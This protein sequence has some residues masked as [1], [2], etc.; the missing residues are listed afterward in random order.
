VL[1]AGDKVALESKQM[2][3]RDAGYRSDIQYIMSELGLDYYN[4]SDSD[5]AA[6][7]SAAPDS[8]KLMNRPV[9][10]KKVPSVI[11]MGLR[12]ALFLLENKGLRV[13]FSGGYGKVVTQSITPGTRAAGQVVYLRL[14]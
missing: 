5:W 3:D 8:L 7:R 1:N 4:K 2:P 9:E 6:L 14:G 11:G 10:D 12:D 13:Q